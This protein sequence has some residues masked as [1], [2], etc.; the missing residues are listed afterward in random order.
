VNDLVVVVVVVV[1]VIVVPLLR[2]WGVLLAA[3]VAVPV[4]YTKTDTGL[5][6]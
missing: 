1:V 6:V 5:F 4:T 3:A 2:C